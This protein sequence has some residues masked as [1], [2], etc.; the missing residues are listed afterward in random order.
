MYKDSNSVPSTE[1]AGRW[2]KE[3]CARKIKEGLME[4]EVRKMVWIL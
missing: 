2:G 1:E 4:E 3:A